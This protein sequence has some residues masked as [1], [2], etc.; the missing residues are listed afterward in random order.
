MIGKVFKYIRF[1]FY[2]MEEVYPVLDLVFYGM[3]GVYTAR[4]LHEEHVIAPPLSWGFY[5]SHF[6]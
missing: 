4:S 3:E 1:G 2:A 6:H 5:F